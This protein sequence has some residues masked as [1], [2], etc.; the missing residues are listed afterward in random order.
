MGRRVLFYYTFLLF[1][2]RLDN[3]SCPPRL[4]ADLS[5]IW[6]IWLSVHKSVTTKK[7]ILFF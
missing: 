1:P 4:F 6:L 5:Q 7:N 2:F 3:A